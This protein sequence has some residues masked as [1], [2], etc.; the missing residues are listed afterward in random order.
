MS[1]GGY[2][3][4]KGWEV[5]FLEGDLWSF[6]T[7]LVFWILLRLFF[8]LLLSWFCSETQKFWISEI[9]FDFGVVVLQDIFLDNFLSLLICLSF[10]K[11]Q[12]FLLQPFSVDFTPNLGLLLGSSVELNTLALIVLSKCWLLRLLG[13]GLFDR[14]EF[15]SW[16]SS[17]CFSW[18]FVLVS[19]GFVFDVSDVS[20]SSALLSWSVISS[21]ST[22]SVK[23]VSFWDTFER[24]S[25]FPFVF[26][27]GSWFLCSVDRD[28]CVNL[29]LCGGGGCGFFELS[30]LFVG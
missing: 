16:L 17:D 18:L 6:S 3:W 12:L 22:S 8:S 25:T 27:F 13:F 21:S 24:S 30:S 4:S 9:V 26:N 1:L 11:S 15:F 5:I 20:V 29:S 10:K 28:F 7:L 14:W 19:V 23:G 2:L